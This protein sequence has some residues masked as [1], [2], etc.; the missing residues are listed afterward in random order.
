MTVTTE[1]EFDAELPPSK[2]QVKRECDA[3][4]KLGEDLIDMKQSELDALNLPEILYD[5]LRTARKIQSRGG[6][7]R[8]RQ[9]IGKIMRQIDS[10]ELKRQVEHLQHRHDTNSAHVRKIERWR[11][12]LLE[13]DKTALSEIIDAYPQIDRQHVNQLIRQ[14]KRELLQEKPPTSARKLFKYLRDL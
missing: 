1:D 8:Q 6:L 10:E 13:N 9:Y 3:L 2:S 5:A 7:K 11:D 12:R 4:Q 14:A